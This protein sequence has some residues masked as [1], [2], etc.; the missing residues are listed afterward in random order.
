M[1]SIPARSRYRAKNRTFTC[2]VHLP[3]EVVLPLP[4]I[5]PGVGLCQLLYLS[6]RPVHLVSGLWPSGHTVLGL[7]S[8]SLFFYAS[9]WSA[10]SEGG[11]AEWTKAA[12]LKTVVRL[13]RTVGS[14][15][16]PS[17]IVRFL[18]LCEKSLSAPRLEWSGNG[19]EQ[20]SRRRGSGGPMLQAVDYGNVHPMS[21]PRL[22]C[23]ICGQNHLVAWPSY[24]SNHGQDI[25]LQWTTATPGDWLVGLNPTYYFRPKYELRA[26]GQ[27][28]HSYVIPDRL[29]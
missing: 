2:R 27:D 19:H 17:A 9:I 11:V 4:M 5:P 3:H 6:L 15:P 10:S 28:Y 23:P 21:L 8:H 24:L 13:S 16:T 25:A 22:G 29:C 14:N 20:L 18:G 26:S 12:V 7:A 1:V